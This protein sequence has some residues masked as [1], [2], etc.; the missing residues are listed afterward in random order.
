MEFLGRLVERFPELGKDYAVH[1][2]GNG[3]ALPHVFIGRVT[4]AVV[5]AYCC[6]AEGAGPGGSG[7]GGSGASASGAEEHGAGDYAALDWRGVLGFLE[8][9]FPAA[10]L[11]VRELIMTRFLMELPWPR[12]PGYGL[13]GC[14]GPVL[15]WRFVQ[16]RPGG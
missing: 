8:E 14:L 12:E 4:Q 10:P 5:A 11:P 13:I 1:V 3:G 15:A 2:E 6:D 9:T 16:A 7:A